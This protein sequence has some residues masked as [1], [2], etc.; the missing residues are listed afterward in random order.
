MASMIPSNHPFS[1]P[2]GKI[3]AIGFGLRPRFIGGQIVPFRQIPFQH[4]K[5]AVAEVGLR[6]GGITFAIAF[7]FI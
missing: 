1:V 3:A 5:S 4:L 7:A 2:S 6:V